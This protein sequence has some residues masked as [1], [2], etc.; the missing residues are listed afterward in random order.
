MSCLLHLSIRGK[1]LDHW[2][3]SRDET[4]EMM[5]EY[6]GVDPEDAMTEMEKTIGVNTRFEF[7]KNVYTYEIL[8]A[9][10]DRGDD[11]HVGLY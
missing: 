4:L 11:E 6:L 7:L 9:L 5:V 8:R 1:L 3:I 2:R 10:E